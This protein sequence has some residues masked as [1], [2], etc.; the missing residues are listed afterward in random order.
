MNIH[1]GISDF[2]RLFLNGEPCQLLRTAFAD[3][4]KKWDATEESIAKNKKDCEI[5]EQ[6]L[7]ARTG[8][9]IGQ[10]C[11]LTITVPELNAS[12]EI[13]DVIRPCSAKIVHALAGVRESNCMHVSLIFRSDDGDEYYIDP[14]RFTHRI[15]S[16]DGKEPKDMLVFDRTASEQNKKEY[17][18]GSRLYDTLRKPPSLPR[19]RMNDSLSQAGLVHFD[20]C[21]LRITTAEYS[22]VVTPELAFIDK[23]R[24]LT[25][26]CH[27]EESNFRT[28]PFAMRRL[29]AG[30]KFDAYHNM[31]MDAR[32][33]RSLAWDI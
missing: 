10:R 23:P 12:G 13:I 6:R 28:N 30:F 15:L 20:D 24:R 32:Q 26:L 5:F 16:I 9:H 27:I 33:I 7:L 17:M 21:L 11:S 3:H 29:L 31:E 19:T 4:E 18:E 2:E 22:F 14:I 8:L 1:F 25:L